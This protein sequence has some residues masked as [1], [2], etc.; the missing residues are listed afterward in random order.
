MAVQVL[1]RV[2]VRYALSN[3]PWEMH[4]NVDGP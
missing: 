4:E 1:C 2:Q 3:H